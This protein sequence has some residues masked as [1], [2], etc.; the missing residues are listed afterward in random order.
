M[1][2]PAIRVRMYRQ[3]LGDCFLVTFDVGGAE[4][5]MLIDCGSLG[6]TTTRVTIADV[7]EHLRETTGGHLDVVL[8]THE[9]QDHVSAFRTERPA[10][11]AMRVDQVWLAW[12]ENPQDPKAQAIARRRDDLGEALVHASDI[13]EDVVRCLIA[14]GRT[15]ILSA[16]WGSARRGHDRA[17]AGRAPNGRAGLAACVHVSIRQSL[18]VSEGQRGFRPAVESQRRNPVSQRGIQLDFIQRHVPCA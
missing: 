7:V 5:H 13:G 14:H 4:G 10:F 3:G 12:T 18:E 17:A 1:P 15:G 11:D 16:G 2:I 6:A 9:H 8:A